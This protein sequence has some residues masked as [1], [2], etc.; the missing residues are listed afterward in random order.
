MASKMI[1]IREDVYYKLAKLKHKNESF[2]ELF[3]RLLLNRKK[4]P[5]KIYGILSEIPE[6]YN[7]LFEKAIYDSRKL[8]REHKNERRKK[9]EE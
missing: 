1:S 3:E 2:S 6:D 4:D 9:I 5:L 7:D 8:K